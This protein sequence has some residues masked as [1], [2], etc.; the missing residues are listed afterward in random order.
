M[1]VLTG[2]VTTAFTKLVNQIIILILSNY[3]LSSPLTHNTP[4]HPGIK[5]HLNPITTHQLLGTDLWLLSETRG[6]V[7]YVHIW[8]TWDGP[9]R[10]HY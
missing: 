2:V 6:G 1:N 3:P 9:S 5:Q 10:M 8:L 7:T 4:S